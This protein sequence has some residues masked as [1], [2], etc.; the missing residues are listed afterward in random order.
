[1]AFSSSDFV[2]PSGPNIMTPRIKYGSH[3]VTNTWSYDHDLRSS[4]SE[5][6]LRK[7]KEEN[8]GESLRQELEKERSRCG[9]LEQKINDI[10][11]TRWAS[12]KRSPAPSS[13]RACLTPVATVAHLAAW[14]TRPPRA[15]KSRPRSHLQPAA[16]KVRAGKLTPVDGCDGPGCDLCVP[17]SPLLSVEKQKDTLA[18]TLL[19]L[20]YD[21]FGVYIEDFRFQ[22]EEQ[23]VEADEPLSGKR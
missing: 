3:R 2:L 8:N 23:T 20:F 7:L 16:V 14:K 6:E 22:P 12:V 11:R 4:L 18:D 19:K 1:M 13:C 15:P 17:F 10:L 21:H 5:E 9:E